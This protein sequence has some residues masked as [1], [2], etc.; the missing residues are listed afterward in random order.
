MLP[1]AAM[2][3]L[4]E[5]TKR[6]KYRALDTDFLRH[7][8]QRQRGYVANLFCYAVRSGARLPSDVVGQV[9]NDCLTRLRNHEGQTEKFLLGRIDTIEALAYAKRT[10]A[11]E[12]LTFQEKAEYRAIANQQHGVMP[13]TEKQLN[14]IKWLGSSEVPSDCL[15]A[16]SLIKRLLKQR[17]S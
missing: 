8:P 17:E 6:R 16:S 11:W 15:S 10:L 2:E 4:K 12:S 9:K 7:F 1:L 13:A 5:L 14:Y 3:S